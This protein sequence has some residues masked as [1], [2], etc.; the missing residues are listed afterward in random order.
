MSVIS[1]AV[2]S[3]LPVSLNHTLTIQLMVIA[4]WRGAFM[5]SSS[6]S[7]VLFVLF[8]DV[9]LV[10]ELVNAKR[11]DKESTEFYTKTEK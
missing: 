5:K 10:A 7:Y 6:A 11:I 4:S 2:R 9:F 8:Q 3:C 1:L